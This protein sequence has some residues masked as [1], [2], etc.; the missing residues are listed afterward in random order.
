M[1]D[2]AEFLGLRLDNNYPIDDDGP[3]LIYA[4]DGHINLNERYPMLH[5]MYSYE[6]DVDFEKYGIRVG[7]Q[8]DSEI[9]FDDFENCP[10]F[11]LAR[12]LAKLAQPESIFDTRDHEYP[13][14]KFIPNH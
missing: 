12:L 6:K 2:I 4:W 1:N 5:V 10:G 14:E 13:I 11:P 3:R 7:L 9:R 8:V